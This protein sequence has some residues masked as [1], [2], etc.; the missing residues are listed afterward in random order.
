MHFDLSIDHEC[1]L[2][3]VLTALTPRTLEHSLVGV[4]V[5][6]EKLISIL[7]G[8]DPP[9]NDLSSPQSISCSNPTL[10]KAEERIGTFSAASLSVAL[11]KKIHRT[12]MVIQMSG[13]SISANLNSCLQP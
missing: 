10:R 11:I 8:I 2:T 5:T 13:Y 6:D 3:R 9:I 12:P 1:F 7:V 4:R